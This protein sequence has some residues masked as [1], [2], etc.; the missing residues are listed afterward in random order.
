[1]R[2][3]RIEGKPGI[4]IVA[5]IILMMTPGLCFGLGRA[6]TDY[7]WV[8]NYDDHTV[9]KID[10]DTHEVAAVIPVGLNPAGI[11]VGFDY[12]YVA[13]MLSSA[14]YRISID[15]DE[16]Y[17]IID[18]SAVMGG[19]TGVAVD[20]A[21]YSF[22][23]GRKA[24]EDPPSTDEAFLAKVSP[25]GL[26]E[27]SFSM[28]DKIDTGSDAPKN[29]GIGLNG[30]GIGFIPWKKAWGGDTGMVEFN[31]DNLT[32]T[33]YSISH[34]YYRVSGVGIDGAGNG[35]SVG[36]RSGTTQTA[37]ITKVVPGQGLTHYIIPREWAD[38]AAVCGGALVDLKQQ[39]WVNS[40]RGLFR[41]IPDSEQLDLFEVDPAGGGMAGDRSGY[42]WVVDHDM[43]QLRK[44][45][46]GGLQVGT[47]VETGASP[48]GYGDMTG[49]ECTYIPGDVDGDAQVGMADH[50]FLTQFLAGGPA[51]VPEQAGDV[52]CSGAVDVDDAIYLENHLFYGGP[53]PCDP[54]TLISCWDHDVDGYMDAFCGGDDCDD[55]D[56]AIFSGAPEICDGMDSDC[57][58][59]LPADEVDEDG[60]GSPLCADCDDAVPDTYPGAPE[61][62]DGLDNDCDGTIPEDETDADE[63]GWAECEGDCDDADAQVNPG[64]AEDCDNGIDDDCDGLADDFDMD[65]AEFSLLMDVSY[66]TSQPGMLDLDF[67]IGA[68]NP[69]VW[70]T[71]AV[72]LFP[73]QQIFPLWMDFL[74]VT[75][76][77]EDM[78]Y[79]FL[80]PEMGGVAIFSALYYGGAKQVHAVDWIHTKK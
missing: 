26:V 6:W 60:D 55:C 37:C 78:A 77:A 71:V 17:D 42:I 9:S 41:F 29:I 19:P 14:L 31:T 28:P 39:V 74:P 25:Q 32:F 1:M 18:L 49:Y 38:W 58:G 56:P 3:P 73:T 43:D 67:R 52:N 62:C 76:P 23:V 20:R 51:P 10:V 47:A 53:P 40:G 46:L 2:N 35:W 66:G 48:Q 11:A 24:G 8:S 15:T 45:G 30:G 61:I 22:V 13:C 59:I 70:V 75:Y 44:Y 64:M 12:V 69:C 54:D 5:L 50:E 80:F 4:F 65:C 16:V 72:K 34:Q 7:L 63:D 79:S 27:A 36:H 68:A 57:D 33:D 21:G